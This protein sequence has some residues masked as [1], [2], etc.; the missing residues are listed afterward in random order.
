VSDKLLHFLRAELDRHVTSPHGLGGECVDLIELWALVLGAAAIPG[1]AVDLGALAD[2]AQWAWTANGPT[3]A[4]PAG[5]I[6]VW[7]PWPAEGIGRNGHT[8][9]A[10]LGSTMDLLTLD[11]NWPTGAPV[12]VNLHD[13]GGVQ[14]WLVRR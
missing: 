14:G 10:L 9:V 8:A 1:N 12:T 7:G 5:A 13:Y 4:P 6:V 11:Q 2:K 3:N